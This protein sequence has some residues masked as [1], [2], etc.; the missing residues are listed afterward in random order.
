M[1]AQGLRRGPVI[2]AGLRVWIRRDV[3][4][5]GPA[6][7]TDPFLQRVPLA[8]AAAPLN[9]VPPAKLPAMQEEGCER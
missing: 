7:G 1:L 9:H 8:H 2:E 3:L 6:L 4:S 5:D